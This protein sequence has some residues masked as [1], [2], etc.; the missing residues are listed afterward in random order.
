MNRAMAMLVAM[1]MLLLL[2]PSAEADASEKMLLDYGNGST[3]WLDAGEGTYLAAASAS[4]DSAGIAYEIR[5]G[6]FASIGGMGN[7]SVGT[8]EC[9]W[10]LYVL[11]DGGWTCSESFSDTVSGSFAVAFYPDPTIIPV[12]TLDEPE[13]WTS[14][15]GDSAST[16]V[17]DSTGTDSPA[18][19]LEW[20]RTYSTGYVD[21]SIIAAG[22]LLYHTTGGDYYGSGTNKM[23]WVHCLDRYTGDIVWSYMFR[24][25]QGYEVTSPLIVGDML[26]VTATNWD[27]Y[28]FDR[29]TGTLYDTMTIEADYP[30]DDNGDVVWEGRT[31]YTGGTT[32][33]YDS[34]AIYFGVADGRVMACSIETLFNDGIRASKLVEQ[35]EYT[36]DSGMTDGRYTG[37]RGCFYYHAPVIADVNGTRVLFIGG[38]EGYLYALDASTGSEIWVQR[39]IDLADSNPYVP[40]TPGSVSAIAVTGDGRLLVTCTDGAMSPGY[41]T[42]TCIDASTGK[43]PDGSDYYWTYT[44]MAG[45]PTTVGDGFY[46]TISPSYGGD[47]EL[48]RA[49][50][51]AIEV[52]SGICKMD[53]DGNMIWFTSVSQTIKAFLTVADGI[54]YTND[55]SIGKYYP[56]GGGVTAFSAEDGHQIWKVRL[57]PYSDSSYSMVAPTVI[58]GKVY[59]ANDYGAVYCISDVQGKSWNDGGELETDSA[60]FRDWSWFALALAAILCICILYRFYRGLG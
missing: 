23:P 52:Q 1:A 11:K 13:A 41:G 50:G 32:P 56:N 38:Y 28:L 14:V 21:S 4:L 8:Q 17:S 43:G 36:P 48:R 42:I 35:W 37:T 24:I 45:S 16:S 22:G 12:E 54:I 10:R 55:Y 7:H 31:F 9:T 30:Y 29:Y 59:V 26:V 44:V 46:C 5:N 27:V 40:G 51:T 47:S 2:V 20:Y 39:I 34:G 18:T 57:E 49:D 33:V 60:G 3:D 25:G 19:P 53:Y 6:W 15:R 58:E